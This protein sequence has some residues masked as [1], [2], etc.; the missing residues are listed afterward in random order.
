MSEAEWPVCTDPQPMLEFLGSKV[1]ER[2]WRLFAC[3]YAR[4]LWPKLD[5]QRSKH[6]VEV[7]EKYADG[8]VHEQDRDRA[9]Q[10]AGDV[11][12]DA[13][14]KQ[15]FVRAA[16]IFGNPFRPITLDPAWQTANVR[17]LAQAIYDDRAFERMPIL[18]D[19]LED[20]GCTHADILTHCRQPGEHVRG[21]W[22]VDLV[23][24]K[25]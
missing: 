11:V 12:I 22:V 2:K 8:I 7:A 13:V 5:D 24:A 18:G 19:A 9:W 3:G 10:G 23:L 14:I 20:A 4:Q 16:D 21:C 17:A 15:D 25:Q 6:A 1:S